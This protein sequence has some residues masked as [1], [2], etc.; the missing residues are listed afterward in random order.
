M[1][2]NYGFECICFKTMTDINFLGEEG[3]ENEI[4]SQG[5]NVLN[6]NRVF[7]FVSPG[8]QGDSSFH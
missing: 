7:V 2:F 3:G 6:S 4:R 5:V 8:I 1:N